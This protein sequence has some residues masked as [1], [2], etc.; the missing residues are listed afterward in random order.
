M[1]ILFTADLH[2]L[3]SAFHHFAEMLAEGDFEAGVI[4]GDIL[5]DGIPDQEME[6]V[7]AAT[8]LTPDDF[9][10]ELPDADD[11][12]LEALDK[13]IEHVHDPDSPWIQA[14]QFKEQKV[15]DI[16]SR[17]G[18]PIFIIPG[19]HDLTGWQDG[20]N[21]F[22]IH[23]RRMTLGR[24]NL[25]GYR[26]TDLR[27]SMEDRIEDLQRLQHLVDRRTILVTHNAPLGILDDV[28]NSA[29]LGSPYI[30]KLVRRRHPRL[31]LFGHIHRSFG[32][33]G[34]FINGAYPRSRQFVSIDVDRKKI[35]WIPETSQSETAG[36][37]EVTV[38]L[39]HWRKDYWV[40]YDPERKRGDG[41]KP[42]ETFLLQLTPVYVRMQQEQNIP[43]KSTVRFTISSMETSG[44]QVHLVRQDIKE[45][46][47]YY[48][49]VTMECH[50]YP[51]DYKLE[52]LFGEFP[53]DL[54]LKMELY[55]QSGILRAAENPDES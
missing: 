46:K 5:D 34:K 55:R 10:P 12:V 49:N 18:K 6:E 25:V 15:R 53:A 38:L 20:G 16:L 28:S 33:R 52:Q 9:L 8:D 30:K 11:N 51:F 37:N 19:N 43:Y 7:Y 21:I 39:H 48:R 4:A 22:N 40:V 13:A 24:Y 45:G 14:L 42:Q 54:Y 1:K 31:H 23:D 17:A 26:W 29:H 50:P 47:V 27:R 44:S 36:R 35:R 41:H 2:G 32:H 3:T